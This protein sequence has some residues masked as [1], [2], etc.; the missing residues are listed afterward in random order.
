MQAGSE[1][2]QRLSEGSDR[3]SRGSHRLYGLGL[4]ETSEENKDNI[5]EIDNFC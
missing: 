1:A 4:L 5:Y 3:L 2:T